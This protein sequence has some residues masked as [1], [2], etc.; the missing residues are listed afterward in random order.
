MIKTL[1][2]LLLTILILAFSTDFMFISFLCFMSCFFPGFLYSLSV[3]FSC[4]CSGSAHIL[5]FLIY[6]CYGP[7]L[8]CLQS[9]VSNQFT[10]PSQSGCRHV[11]FPELL[12]MN[13]LCWPNSPLLYNKSVLVFLLLPSLS[14]CVCSLWTT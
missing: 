9:C 6:F 3:L 5:L 1:I 4:L 8:F 10:P 14:F 12:F 7:F 11:S 2:T 13:I